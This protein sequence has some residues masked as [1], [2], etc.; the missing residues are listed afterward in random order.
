MGGRTGDSDTSPRAASQYI[1]APKVRFFVHSHCWSACRD[2]PGTQHDPPLLEP[3]PS[4]ARRQKGGHSGDLW[5]SLRADRDEL[6]GSFW[7]PRG[8]SVARRVLHSLWNLYLAWARFA[9]RA[10]LFAS[11]TPSGPHYVRYFA[12][13]RSYKVLRLFICAELNDLEGISVLLKKTRELFWILPSN[14]A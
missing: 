14:Q 13:L 8:R 12:T 3:P 11:L 6:L 1:A 4:A 2:S 9:M 5:S 7:S 10:W